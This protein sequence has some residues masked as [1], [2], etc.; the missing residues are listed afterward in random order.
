[1]RLLR[2]ADD[3]SHEQKLLL[4]S[5][6]R[7][8][9]H[10]AGSQEIRQKAGHCLFGFRA[11][12]GE[13]TFITITPDRRHSNL[14]LHL[15]RVR[16]N[17]SSLEGEDDVNA[18]RRKVASEFEPKLVL[19]PDVEPE[20]AYKYLPL[21]PLP[22]RQALNARDPLSS[23]QHYDVA[24]RVILSCILGIRM[25]MQCPNCND[26]DKET[27]RC[28][29]QNKFGNNAKVFGGSAGYCDHLVGM[30]ENQG[31][32]TP[33]FHGV[34]LLMTIYQHRTLLEIAELI[35]KDVLSAYEIK[36]YHEHLC[37]EDHYKHEA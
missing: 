15:S 11:T 32:G 4:N 2:S 20:E 16:K 31:E 14:L 24:I 12:L 10:F 8:S 5:Y 3:L 27:E 37:R 1:M 29:C 22:K 30:T 6:Q 33:H 36:A 35:E 13:G 26:L 28:G 21:P 9:K 18:C 19:P 7:V 34:M 25:C 17:D 23:V